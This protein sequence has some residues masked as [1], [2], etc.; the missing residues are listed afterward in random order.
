MRKIIQIH[1]HRLENNPIFA[2]QF[3]TNISPVGGIGRRA[4]LKL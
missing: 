4:R 1:F 2:H 3:K